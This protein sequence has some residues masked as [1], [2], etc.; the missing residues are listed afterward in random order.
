MHQSY[1]AAKPKGRGSRA[2]AVTLVL[3]ALVGTAFAVCAF[4]A[5]GA[6]NYGVFAAPANAG[7]TVCQCTC[8]SDMFDPDSGDSCLATCRAP[9]DSAEKLAHKAGCD[10]E[11]NG[12]S[13]CLIDS[14]TCSNQS[15]DAPR[16]GPLFSAL[17]D[18]E[19]AGLGAGGSSAG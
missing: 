11:F 10:A 3:A 15:F 7:P 6:C 1:R 16:C 19:A 4:G 8:G 5:V 17:T 18:C 2:R 9:F 13:K 14:G 12:Y